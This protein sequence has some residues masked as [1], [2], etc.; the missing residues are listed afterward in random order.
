EV[1]IQIPVTDTAQGC[2]PAL[3]KVDPD[4]P[5]AKQRHV[6][7]DVL[8]SEQGELATSED[9]RPVLE[10]DRQVHLAHID[11]CAELIVD[12]CVLDL[13]SEPEVDPQVQ[14]GFLTLGLERGE[15]REQSGADARVRRATVV[16][17][18]E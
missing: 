5:D 9:L 6:V 14:A 12:T 2:S 11:L 4:G 15:R 13:R 3:T 10:P 1:R 8:A 16:D 17:L 7:D 18:G